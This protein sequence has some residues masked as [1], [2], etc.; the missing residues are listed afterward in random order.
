M[1]D[2]SDRNRPHA[3]LSPLLC[4]AGFRCLPRGWAVERG[5]RRPGGKTHGG[6]PDASA[7]IQ[8]R[9]LPIHSPGTARRT[10]L[11]SRAPS[12]QQRRL[13]YRDTLAKLPVAA[14][15][16]G[17]RFVRPA[18]TRLVLGT[19]PLVRASGTCPGAR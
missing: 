1:C 16:R 4:E 6:C 10:S 19:A 9:S 15:D 3:S 18:P 5:V 11:P 12:V 14:W 2:V 7:V 8:A 17:G 13:P